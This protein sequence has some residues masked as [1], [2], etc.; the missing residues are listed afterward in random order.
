MSAIPYWRLSAVYFFY[1]TFVGAFA[2]YFGLYLKSLAFS[3]FQIGVLMSLYQIAR[4][5]M[6]NAW[7][8]L[9]DHTGKGVRIVQ[10]TCLAS[11]V[12]YLG[13][14]AGTSFNWL[15]VCIGLM[16]VFWSAPMPLLEAVTLGHLKEASS[17]YGR[18][19]LWGSIGFIATVV[20]LGYLLDYVA[21]RVLLWAILGLMTGTLLVTFWL[22]E[23]AIPHHESAQASVWQILRRPE[24]AAFLASCFLM[25]AAHGVYYT[26]YSIY[27]VDHG[28]SKT[29][30]GLL[31]ATG[32]LCE[33]LLFLAM[34]RLAH[35]F[36][37]RRILLASFALAVVRFLLMGWCVA[38]VTLMVLA[39]T[40]HAATF[41]SF[42]ASS[43]AVTQRFFRGRHHSRGQALYTSVSYGLGGTVGGLVSGWMWE[44]AGPALTFS[45][46]SVATMIGFLLLWRWLHLERETPLR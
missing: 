42:H 32:V 1:C 25:A 3:A 22:P 27:L 41:G 40:L 36:G 24:V 35:R 19:R 28:Y 44:R 8:W 16:C 21:I 34:P 4:I 46:S 37:L 6:P 12:L 5:F 20:G 31:W 10:L 14:F 38:S 33:I 26:F 7:G 39:Q 11:L 45:V 2:P 17:G 43:V 9:A 30:V 18:I 15:L 23:V 29:A 13:V